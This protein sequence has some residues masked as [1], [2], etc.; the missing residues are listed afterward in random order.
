MKNSAYFFCVIMFLWT[1][2]LTAME[3]LDM[4]GK[5]INLA[6]IQNVLHSNRVSI[7]ARSVITPSNSNLG[8]TTIKEYVVNN[9]CS[10]EEEYL[11]PDN[12]V[13]RYYTLRYGS[14]K[15]EILKE[16][17]VYWQD[18]KQLYLETC[19]AIGIEPLLFSNA[20][21]SVSNQIWKG[22]NNNEVWINVSKKEYT[23]LTVCFKYRND[24]SY[25]MRVLCKKYHNK[26]SQ[27]GSRVLPDEYKN[28]DLSWLNLWC[29]QEFTFNY[30]T[31]LTTVASNKHIEFMKQKTIG[32]KDKCKRDRIIF[33]NMNT[34]GIQ[35]LEDI[36]VYQQPR[37]LQRGYYADTN[38]TVRVNTLRYNSPIDYETIDL[39]FI[40]LNKMN[41]RQNVELPAHLGSSQSFQR[42]LVGLK[43]VYS[44]ERY[45]KE[46]RYVVY[47]NN[48]AILFQKNQVHSI[49]LQKALKDSDDY[50]LWNILGFAE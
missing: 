23:A 32:I 2:S 28:L 48:L 16:I 1:P 6:D 10:E 37:S 25:S 36:I 43:I 49:M 14:A 33:Q 45:D 41:P 31:N 7:C 17:E 18:G 4:L 5:P 27:E 3:L 47:E 34:A 39:I 44:T 30:D 50:G 12:P 38:K 15:D 19:D 29:S 11:L 22:T 46:F 21:H 26:F 20:V 13:M 40:N 8:R 42:S 35:F 9:S 24:K